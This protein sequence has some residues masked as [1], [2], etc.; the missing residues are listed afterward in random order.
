M[1]SL[2]RRFPR[3]CEVRMDAFPSEVQG[4]SE[5]R[6]RPDKPYSLCARCERA[7]ASDL[8]LHTSTVTERPIPPFQ[9]GYQLPSGVVATP[10]TDR[11]GLAWNF[12]PCSPTARRFEGPRKSRRGPVR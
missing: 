4:G 8:L 12:R 5:V 6:I 1:P 11:I 3:V 7:L 2:N 9:S 10:T